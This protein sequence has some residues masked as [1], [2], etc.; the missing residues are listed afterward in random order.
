MSDQFEMFDPRISEGSP[1][2]TSSPAADSGPSRSGRPG[3]PTTTKSGPEAVP[4]LPLAQRAK[5]KG[6]QTLVTSGRNGYGSSA[7]ADLEQSLASRLQRRLDTAGSILFQE[8][9]K[10]KTTPLRRRYWEH[11]ASGR[12]TSGSGFTSWPSP[13]GSEAAPDYAILDR[14][15]SGGISIATAATLAG[16]ATPVHRDHRNSAGEN[17]GRSQGS[18]ADNPALASLAGWPTPMA[19]SPATEDYNEAG[20]SGSSR[21]TV[22]LAAWPSPCT[23][24]GGRSTSPEKMDVTGMTT[25][26]RKHAATLE[27][28]VKFSGPARL[29]ASGEMLTGSDAAMESGGQLNPAHSRWLMGV[30]PAW[31]G[32]AS[33]AM[34]SVSRRRKRSSRP[35]S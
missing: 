24:S 10:R 6:L 8:T 9:W 26:G 34:Q 31:D 3:G 25:D 18:H 32:F 17:S 11:T 7:S 2:V 28:A 15:E 19:Q 5:G 14:P 16:W 22:E 35:T 30:P 13:K 12:R 21:K 20:N 23:P 33:T 4:V 27:H 29:T 1:N